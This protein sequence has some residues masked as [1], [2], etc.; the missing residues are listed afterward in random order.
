M[1]GWRT[2]SKVIQLAYLYVFQNEENRLKIEE[3]SYA[4]GAGFV[5]PKTVTSGGLL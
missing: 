1:V 3:V 2:D 5:W 4:V